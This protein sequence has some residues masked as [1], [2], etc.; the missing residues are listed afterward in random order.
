MSFRSQLVIDRDT[1]EVCLQ[2]TLGQYTSTAPL[3]DG[4]GTW[5][6]TLQHAFIET[7]VQEMID[8]L[9]EMKRKDQ[10][11]LERKSDC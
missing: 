3:P 4:F 2:V 1:R 11:K 9:M 7:H 8:G 5:S 10:K 6:D